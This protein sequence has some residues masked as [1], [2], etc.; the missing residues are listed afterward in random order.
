MRIS[1]C[2]STRRRR[3]ASVPRG[4]SDGAA[5]GVRAARTRIRAIGSRK[6]IV[7]SARGRRRIPRRS[8]TATS[9]GMSRRG[10]SARRFG[11]RP[12][13][14][15]AEAGVTSQLVRHAAIGRLPTV[16]RSIG[17]RA[18]AGGA[19][20]RPIDRARRA[21]ESPGVTSLHRRAT[22]RGRPSRRGRARS[23]SRGSGSR[24]RQEKARVSNRV[25]TGPG[26]LSLRA[27]RRGLTDPG[28]TNR[29]QAKSD[30]GPPSRRAARRGP[31]D[32][33]A[34]NRPQARSDPGLPRRRAPA[35]GGLSAAVARRIVRRVAVGGAAGR[36]PA[37]NG[38]GAGNRAARSPAASAPVVRRGAIRSPG[39]RSRS[40]RAVRRSPMRDAAAP[41]RASAAT[42]NRPIATDA[43][44]FS[45]WRRG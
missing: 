23:E 6:G 14:H 35:I 29:P 26:P 2:R 16:T 36:H 34:R 24:V 42:T 27:T 33:G 1:S 20:R 41:A 37:T 13:G 32:P 4:P 25:A 38:P 44:R 22:D 18:E 19:T 31:T 43:T 5:T 39:R 28:A 15:R 11:V 7:L 8:A 9:P 30:P 21:N 45:W 40:G 10:T 3:R 12:L 17:G